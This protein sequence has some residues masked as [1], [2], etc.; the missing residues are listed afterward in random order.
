M[1]HDQ[2]PLV[3]KGIYGEGQPLSADDDFFFCSST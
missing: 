1:M 3:G 2:P